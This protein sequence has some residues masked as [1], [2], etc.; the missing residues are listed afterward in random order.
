MLLTLDK[1]LPLRLKLGMLPLIKTGVE[2]NPS[3]L[4]DVFTIKDFVDNVS[5]SVIS[6]KLHIPFPLILK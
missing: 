3:T 4:M 2:R 5:E 6:L 1:P